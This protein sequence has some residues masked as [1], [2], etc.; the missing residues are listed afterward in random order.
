MELDTTSE[1]D[2]LDSL[3]SVDSESQGGES[4]GAEVPGRDAKGVTPGGG[5]T[6]TPP[7][8][9]SGD[10]RG[11]AWSL[12][13]NNYD[14]KV[15]EEFKAYA[16]LECEKYTFQEEKGAEGTPHIQA[17][18]Y[19]KSQRLFSAIKK[20]W[21]TAHIEKAK[22]WKAL[23]AYCRKV[24]SRAGPVV[25][26]MQRAKDPLE[27]KTLFTW[28][29]D[30]VQ[31]IKGEPDDRKIT[32]IV[33]NGGG[34]GKTQLAKHLCLSYPGEVLYV[35][36]AGADVRY[37]VTKFIEDGGHLRTCIFG[38]TKSMESR[39]SYEALEQVKDGIFYN[40]K[41]ESKMVIYDPPHVIVFSNWLPDRSKLSADRWDVIVIDTEDGTD[42]QYPVDEFL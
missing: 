14:E 39:V 21:P 38:F 6:S 26:N 4:A 9:V 33:N 16:K 13:I 27:G 18:L 19:F 24:D 30:L 11:R 17:A 32:W 1:V 5:N 15:L 34:I 22:S 40:T 29:H 23:E 41:F 35:N 31:K 42:P 37:G 2:S 3:I 20:K 36:G 10:P 25:T 12:T 28:Q 7:A 8:R